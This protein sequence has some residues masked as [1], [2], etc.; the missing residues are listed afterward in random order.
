VATSYT[1]AKLMCMCNEF[2]SPS[3]QQRILQMVSTQKFSQF[4]K[5]DHRSALNDL[6]ERI[7]TLAPMCPTTHKQDAHLKNFLDNACIGE[8]WASSVL[9]RTSAD[10]DWTFHM[11][12]THLAAAVQQFVEEQDDR[13]ISHR[14]T[15]PIIPI[16]LLDGRISNETMSR[17]PKFYGVSTQKG[18]LANREYKSCSAA[19]TNVV[20]RIVMSTITVVLLMSS[21]PLYFY[22]MSSHRDIYI[23]NC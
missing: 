6:A 11:M 21:L 5:D 18:R 2:N 10:P 15:P 16:N 22:T 9:R 1:D 17:T 23:Y 8:Q 19:R 4:L 13:R 3:R 7:S 14:K 20:L 12:A